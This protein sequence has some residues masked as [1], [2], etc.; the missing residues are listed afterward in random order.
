[1][2]A[3]PKHGYD[4]V[5]VIN[6]RNYAQFV[7]GDIENPHRDAGIARHVVG[8]SLVGAMRNPIHVGRLFPLR[9]LHDFDKRVDAALAA[10]VRCCEVMERLFLGE[11]HVVGGFPSGLAYGGRGK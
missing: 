9:R 6:S 7:I 3:N 2:R 4:C 11:L 1:M 10:R 5:E 8:A